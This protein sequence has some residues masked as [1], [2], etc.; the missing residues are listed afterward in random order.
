MNCAYKGGASR[1]GEEDKVSVVR[2]GE[3]LKLSGIVERLERKEVGEDG[4]EEG[5]WT[6]VVGMCRFTKAGSVS[7]PLAF[8][9]HSFSFSLPFVFFLLSLSLALVSNIVF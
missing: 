5:R 1:E 6:S 8:A 2:M 4:E 7:L 3:S 9:G